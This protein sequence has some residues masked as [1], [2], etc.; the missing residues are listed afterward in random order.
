MARRT[1]VLR[2]G[3][4]GPPGE[5]RALDV[6]REYPFELTIDGRVVAAGSFS[7]PLGDQGWRDAATQIERA[8]QAEERELSS[9]RRPLEI[10]R[11]AGRHLFASVAQ[12]APELRAFLAD[13]GPRRLVIFTS[14]P[15]LH[16]LP[17]EAMIDEQWAHPASAD[18]SIV[19]AAD[20]FDPI[21]APIEP[22]LSVRIVIGPRTE[23]KTLPAIEGLLQRASARRIVRAPEGAVAAM[24]HVEA[25]GDPEKG[26]I[27]LERADFLDTQRS[28]TMV[29]LWSCVSNL[30]QPWGESLAMKLHRQA[31]RLV[32]GFTTPVREDT[33][34]DL[35]RRFY[36][37]VFEGRPPVDPETALTALRAALYA[38]RL[39]ACEWASLSV[40]LNGAVDLDAAVLDGPR[41]PADGWT[42]AAADEEWRFVR[43]QLR[44]FGRRGCIAVV[45]NATAG[46][47]APAD[48]AAEYRGAAIHLR[49]PQWTADLD[50][51]LPRL[52]ARAP[53]AHPGDS[54]VAAMK[55]LAAFPD[56][57]LIWTGAGQPEV[58]ALQWLSHLPPG[59]T[60]LL[61]SPG[62]VAVPVGLIEAA[63]GSDASTSA[64]VTAAAPDALETLEA[65][66]R[67][68]RYSAGVERWDALVTDAA[69][70]DPER[71]RRLY[72]AGYWCFIRQKGRRAEAAACLDALDRVAPSE[73]A[74]LR[75]N[76]ASRDHHNDEALRRYR[77]A[78]RLAANPRDEGRALL[79]QAYLASQ[80]PDGGGAE[81][82]FRDALSRLESANERDDDRWRSALG[83][84]LR[85]YADMLVKLND[86]LDEVEGYLE[87]ALVIHAIDGRTS[88]VAA[89]L[90]TCGHL[91]RTRGQYAKAEQ[92]AGAA[93]VLQNQFGNTVG[94]LRSMRELIELA[95]QSGAPARALAMAERLLATDAAGGDEGR[96]AAL[97]A[98]AS[99]QLGDISRAA[100]W[101]DKALAALPPSERDQRVALGIIRDVAR[102]LGPP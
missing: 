29:L 20:R 19:H 41:L 45:P 54:L 49:Q 55:A 92:A 91:E 59:L 77:E 26:T 4:V 30:M 81:V 93:V 75:G 3:E 35:A 57:V 94:R 89:A 102:S 90:E 65:C 86:R 74:L 53:S 73:A 61:V 17:W 71:L 87:R 2:L 58:D 32:L 83:R 46:P 79:E 11:S 56:S 98:R 72:A 67:A 39:R 34:G 22:P 16:A 88:Q 78:E 18:L 62:A 10:V 60:I 82:L 36:D 6:Q 48:A 23:R 97:A 33:A 21:P 31:N 85:D 5:L 12:L 24:V 51:C 95:L 66:E 44:T 96:I 25:H 101:A 14:R 43:D 15:E 52:G 84:A 13:A 99:W 40:W 37:A 63:S 100:D 8:A 47:Q 80:R 64:S 28:A 50:A 9:L 70:W 76:L 7:S 1:A 38:E 68:G 42:T 69:R 27:E